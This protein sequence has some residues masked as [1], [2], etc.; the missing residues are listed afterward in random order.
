M[1][2]Q[3]NC[4]ML[5]VRFVSLISILLATN[6]CALSQ[7]ILSERTAKRTR[8]PLSHQAERSEAPSSFSVFNPVKPQRLE[9]TYYPI[10]AKDSAGSWREQ[11]ARR[12]WQEWPSYPP[13]EPPSIDR[14]NTGHTGQVFSI[15]L[16]LV[17]REAPLEMRWK[18]VV[19]LSYGKIHDI[20]ACRN[21]RSELASEMWYD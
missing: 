14:E 2:G 9:E 5:S 20:S 8:S 1:Q 6:L 16:G 19:G 17:W 4:S 13:V 3:N 7:A 12:T 18:Q 15:A 10:P 11:L 21:N